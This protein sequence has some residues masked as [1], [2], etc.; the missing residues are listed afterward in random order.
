ACSRGAG[1][2]GTNRRAERRLHRKYGTLNRMASPSLPAFAGIASGAS[3]AAILYWQAKAYATPPLQPVVPGPVGWK[4]PVQERPA[5]REPV[6]DNSPDGRQAF[7][8]YLRSALENIGLTHQQAL[9][10]LAHKARESGW[11][12]AVWN[13]NFGNIKTGS[14][15]RGPWFWLT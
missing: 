8:V 1:H 4:G 7:V 13:Y 3:T 11:G 5:V 2:G 15:L 6:F 14:T 10:F 9:L 12:K